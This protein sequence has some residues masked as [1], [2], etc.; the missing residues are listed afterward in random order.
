V[1][2]FQR[3]SL[4]IVSISFY[5]SPM[6]KQTIRA[7]LLILAVAGSVYSQAPSQ[8]TPTD[9]AP[10]TTT[11]SV[12]QDPPATAQP[13]PSPSP[14][15]STY[16]FPDNRERFRRYVKS[17]V[18]PF[19]LA[20]HAASAGIQQANDSPEEW[21]QGMKGYGKRFASNL[22]RNAIQQTVTYGL[23][24]A[25]DLD[26]G[27]E[28]SKRSGFF[29]RLKDA[30]VQNVTSRTRSGNRIISVPRFVGVYS[31]AVIAS[32]TWYPER[33]SYKD[34]LRAGTATLIIGF[35][36]NV[37]REFLFNF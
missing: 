28:R 1:N 27:F 35:G 11:Q 5:R 3:L 36:F 33:Y 19:A 20:R 7:F 17:T 22:G 29:P 21:E 14:T 31:G 2:Q 8:S 25:L 9:T 6:A 34:G 23:D 15:S 18:G 13:S 26:T 32:E 16:V 12:S 30:L 24:E 37:V 10:Q 4:T